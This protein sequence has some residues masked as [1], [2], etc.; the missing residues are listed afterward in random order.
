[1]PA[2]GL[3]LAILFLTVSPQS[4]HSPPRFPV[5][6]E[7]LDY[8][9]LAVQARIVGD[10]VVMAEVDSEGRVHVTIP[11]SGHQLL[12]QAAAENLR[13]WRFQ[14]GE[15]QELEI[16]YHF[17]IND[18]PAVKPFSGYVLDLPDSVTITRDPPP[19]NI[20]T[21]PLGNPVMK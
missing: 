6:I 3:L 7:S 17:Q 12:A 5:H 18:K 1:M 2:R 21:S 11:K 10:V 19:V 20:H 9:S 13:K 15:N 14:T 16:T 8:P 4:P